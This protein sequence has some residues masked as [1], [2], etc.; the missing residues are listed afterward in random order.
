MD[1]VNSITN[2]AA[3]VDLDNDGDLDLVTNN[4]NK[5]AFVYQNLSK[6]KDS[7]HN[8]LRISLKQSGANPKAFGSTVTVHS[9]DK[10]WSFNHQPVKD[11]SH[12]WIQE[13]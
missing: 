3:Y 12:Q 1:N 10:Q 9:E 7:A 8:H 2:G 5:A 13:S 6:Q 4:L 11:S